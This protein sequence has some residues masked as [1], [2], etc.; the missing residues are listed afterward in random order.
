MTQP[1]N[2]RQTRAM[3]GIAMMTGAMFLLCAMDVTVKM[4]VVQDY[5]PLQVL[6]VRGWV[7][8]V[9]ML[10]ALPLAGG[11][12]AVRTRRPVA[13]LMR[14][15]IAII[16]P[17]S[18]FT[19]LKTVPLADATVVFFAAPLLTTAFSALLLKEAVGLH[20]W[21][22]ILVGFIGVMIAVNPT[23]S[24]FDP[25][26]VL[27]LIATV[28]YSALFLSGRWL[29]ATE[30]TF[31][32]VFYFNIG[33]TMLAT[34]AAPFVWVPMPD[35]ILIQMAVIG[36][37]AMAGHFMVTNAFVSAPVAIVAPFEYTALI[38]AALLGFAVF[39]DVPGVNVWTGAAVIMASGLYVLHRENR[40]RKQ[41]S[42]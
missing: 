25:A 38:W 29:S 18:F 31:C 41:T 34:A 12:R 23:P 10:A 24:A 5:H 9:L 22:A 15:V 28:S 39:G 6:A 33:I 8:V 14:G 1:A 3:R 40:A 37:L 13:V 30:G 42:S 35:D 11:V 32:L 17:L 27:V 4:V 20:R 36:V 2:L 16:A 7:I 21:S 19:A 26:M